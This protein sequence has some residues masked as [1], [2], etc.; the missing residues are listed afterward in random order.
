[1]FARVRGL[2]STPSGVFTIFCALLISLPS[3]PL[4]LAPLLVFGVAALLSTPSAGVGVVV[5]AGVGVGV[6]VGAGVGVGA[7]VAVG[8]GVGVGV[9]VGAGVGVGAGVAVGAG[10]GVGAGVAVGA[11]VGVG[12]VVG[13]GVGVGAGVVV[14]AG[15]GAGAATCFDWNIAASCSTGTFFSSAIRVKK[16]SWLGHIIT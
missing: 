2:L 14:G 10:V 7:G 1:M 11:G 3:C 13:A 16:Q 8:A 12:V 5:G 6:V 9:V 15:V 4:N